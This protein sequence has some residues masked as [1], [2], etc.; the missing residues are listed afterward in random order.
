MVDFCTPLLADDEAAV[1]DDAVGAREAE[2]GTVTVTRVVVAN[3][4]TGVD[5]GAG[6]EVTVTVKMQEAE[7]SRPWLAFYFCVSNL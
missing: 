7:D 6:V 4:V 2:A 1:E 3:A 5:S